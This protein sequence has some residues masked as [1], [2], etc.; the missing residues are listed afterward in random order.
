MIGANPT[1][2]HPV[3]AT[4]IKNA[5][6]SGI[7]LVVADPRQLELGRHADICLKN[8]PG[9]DIALL[10]AMMNVII[11]EGLVDHEFIKNRTSGFEEIRQSVMAFDPESM[12]KIC[13]IDAET[14]RKAARMYAEA[15]NAMILWGM[16]ISQHVHGTDNVRCLIAL[17]L[18]TGQIGRPG[19]GLHPLR[20][21]NNVQGASDAGLIPMM[22]PDYRPVE[23]SDAQAEFEQH[24]GATLNPERGLT[25]V[26]VLDGIMD[27]NIKGMYIMGEN[28][29]MSD[30]DTLHAR[31][32]IS[33]LEMLVVQDIFMTETAMLSDVILPASA[34]PE[35]S[36]TFTNTDRMVQLGRK[37]LPLPGDARQDLWIIQ[38]MAK[39]L[40]LSWN[41]EGLD[42]GV[43]Q[44]F[45]EMRSVMHSISGITWARLESEHSV[46]YPCKVEGDPGEPVLFIDKFPTSDGLGHFVPVN[47]SSAAEQPDEAYPFVLITGR[48]LEHWHTG[49]MTRRSQTLDAL[50]PIPTVAMHP[51]DVRDIGGEAGDSVTISSRR[52]SVVLSIKETAMVPE[53]VVFIPF[54]YYEAPAN[55]LTNPKLD[56]FGKIPEFKY[57]AVNVS[58]GGDLIPHTSFGGGNTSASASITR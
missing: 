13:G 54:C 31:L 25:V 17:A 12:E 44:V 40:G 4:W 48:E 28:P 39:R 30:P 8:K 23:D 1:E 9:S 55:V 50:Q 20:G 15:K 45:E 37:M 47:L 16:G 19:A 7:K 53:G 21:Q 6:K 22:Y 41:Y 36:G 18:M 43:A 58:L 33:R 46:T 56:P 57:C 10:S 32:A 38:E 11:S 2:N 24:W 34:F 14:I 29:A 5:A 49:A 52:G 42:S 26:E 27:G 35:K 3:A 51:K